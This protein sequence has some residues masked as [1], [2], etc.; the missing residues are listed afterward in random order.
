MA[1]SHYT[2]VCT[3]E[4]AADVWAAG[5]MQ[6]SA[7]MQYTGMTRALKED[8]AAQL[9]ALG[10]NWVTGMSSPWVAGYTV[11]QAGCSDDTHAEMALRFETVTS[12]GPPEFYD[13]KLWLTREDSF[14]RVERIWI[15]EGLYPYTLYRP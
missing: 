14:W 13:A 11:T 3:P 5:L 1:A 8:Y 15:E 6:R 2:G 10:S 4:Q 12:Y 7:A 9:D